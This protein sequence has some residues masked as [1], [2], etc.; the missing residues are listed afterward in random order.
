MPQPYESSAE[1]LAANID[2]FVDAVYESLESSFL[3][4]PRGDSSIQYPR[5]QEAYETLKRATNAFRDFTP[6]TVWEALRADSLALVVVRTILGMTPPEWAELASTDTGVA[7]G[8]GPARALDQRA[9][10]ERGYIASLTPT[11]AAL[12]LRRLEA[13]VNVACA[14]ITAG[15]PAGA[16]DTVHRLDKIDTAEG[17]ASVQRVADIHVP[18]A[19]LLYERYLGRPF[20]SHRD[21][22]SELV[23][24]V[25]ESAVESRLHAARI[26]NRKTGRAER[27]PNF[28]QAPDFMIPDELAP[29]VVIE[30]KISNDDGTARDKIARIMRLSDINRERV[31]RGAP[32]YEVVACIDG[33]G[34]G[35]RR[36]LMRQ[37]LLSV[38]GKVFTL[39]TLDQLIPHTRLAAFASAGAAG[40][41]VAG[42]GPAPP[43]PPSP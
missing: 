41:D 22:V 10:A 20:A 29:Q 40:G 31:A 19:V 37:L 9:R 6:A 28:P 4:M 36:D 14:Y 7:V 2:G 39:R 33:R 8:Q 16:A 38:N 27:L 25:M 26:T 30:A 35:V 23:G 1:E 13:L 5:F 17:L 11:R 12:T 3:V 15:A 43:A 21:A 34:F 18:Y 32:E 42:D 24:E